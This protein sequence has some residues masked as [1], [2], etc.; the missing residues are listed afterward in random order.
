MN[1]DVANIA[2]DPSGMGTSGNDR[3]PYQE[4]FKFNDP[5][6]M[7]ELEKLARDMTT[8]LKA[9]FYRGEQSTNP[10]RQRTQKNIERTGAYFADQVQVAVMNPAQKLPVFY[11]VSTA[12]SSMQYEAAHG[13]MQRILQ[14]FSAGV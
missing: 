11:I 1:V 7:D 10:R 6:M 2:L 14:Q 13:N 12:N 5:K 4:F 8:A 9:D 3:F